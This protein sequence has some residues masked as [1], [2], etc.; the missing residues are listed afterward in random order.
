VIHP[1]SIE[2][3]LE[4]RCAGSNSR[5]LTRLIRPKEELLT[6]RHAWLRWR[7]HRHLFP[8]FYVSCLISHAFW[9]YSWEEGLWAVLE[10]EL[11]IPLHRRNEVG[12]QFRH[13]VEK[14]GGYVPPSGHPNVGPILFHCGI[15]MQA[16][17]AFAQLIERLLDCADAR[18]LIENPAFL[19]SL[20]DDQ[21]AQI[22]QKGLR[23]FLE[24]G[25]DSAVAWIQS[26]LGYRLSGRPLVDHPDAPQELMRVLEEQLCQ[27]AP[28]EKGS[29]VRHELSWDST[30]SALKLQ[31]GGNDH[32]NYVIGDHALAEGTEEHTLR[33]SDLGKQLRVIAPDKE[34]PLSVLPQHESVLLFEAFTGKRVRRREIE[35]GSYVLVAGTPSPSTADSA[36][37]TQEPSS[38]ILDVSSLR[39]MYLEVDGHG[40][41]RHGSTCWKVV[42]NRSGFRLGSSPIARDI[43]GTA[44]YCRP[45]G[46]QHEVETTLLLRRIDPDTEELL[47]EFEIDVDPSQATRRCLSEAQA[48]LY[49]IIDYQADEAQIE[50]F[51]LLPG[52]LVSPEVSLGDATRSC[53]LRLRLPPQAELLEFQGE[54]RPC[55][56]TGDHILSCSF[57]GLFTIRLGLKL[58]GIECRSELSLR[59]SSRF[60]R[61]RARFR[62]VEGPCHFAPLPLRLD[63]DQIRIL[64]GLE[65]MLAPK[66]DYFVTVPGL[67]EAR[68]VTCDDLGRNRAAL[69]LEYV[70]EAARKNAPFDATLLLR[71][72][73]GQ[74]EI[75]ILEPKELP[76]LELDWYGAGGQVIG[77]RVVAV[78]VDLRPEL[79]LRCRFLPLL[80]LDP[81]TKMQSCN[82]AATVALEQGFELPEEQRQGLWLALVSLPG[83]NAEALGAALV[84]CDAELLQT[85]ED[86]IESLVA[87]LLLH[88]DDKGAPSK[89]ELRA[90]AESWTREDALQLCAFLARS[91]TALDEMHGVAAKSSA[92]QRLRY[93]QDLLTGSLTSGGRHI[94]LALPAAALIEA[95]SDLAKLHR[96][97][98]EAFTQGSD[99]TEF[100]RFV[101]A[102]RRVLE[103]VDAGRPEQDPGLRSMGAKHPRTLSFLPPRQHFPMFRPLLED[104]ARG[105]R[106]PVQRRLRE[107]E[108]HVPFA[109]DQPLDEGFLYYSCA[110]LWHSVERQR[111][112]PDFARFV[113]TLTE[114]WHV[115]QGARQIEGLHPL[116]EQV[117]GWCAELRLPEHLNAAPFFDYLA[118]LLECTAALALWNRL[119]AWRC[120]DYRSFFGG[121]HTETPL[122][123]LWEPMIEQSIWAMRT[124]PEFYGAL[125]VRADLCL[126]RGG[127]QPPQLPKDA[128]APSALPSP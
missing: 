90:L 46:I 83:R 100:P 77:A 75:P 119:L 127:E 122:R 115:L 84:C 67:D 62:N 52:L 31:F 4:L 106:G 59:V 36:K 70:V 65:L 40:E 78:E 96:P 27:L 7:Q 9:R 35:A 85:R 88:R 32:V 43:G 117:E 18:D 10:H 51:W 128:E 58:P 19:R 109:V 34:R 94:R 101:Q 87:R 74:F 72:A 76:A 41:L 81:K 82:A 71:D 50:Q 102:Y 121:I 45:P 60:A 97:A 26:L 125:L 99:I 54:E 49:E 5:T 3:S 124:M 57:Q 98:L 33:E 64:E 91:R 110:P 112:R 44:I 89:L 118:Q 61:A 104:V 53:E 93:A 15:P 120:Q 22:P 55:P 69:P 2:Q 73:T 111:L 17:H 14:L 30:A 23:K 24:E 20:L 66:Q 92:G 25:V 6:L 1:Q 13:A 116:L 47:E 8:R 123:R 56:K 79:Q 63:L 16:A 29:R 113:A 86:D 126:A 42:A 12:R 11:E 68:S 38:P 108:K 103:W 105:Q 107:F 48:G 39:A 21:K 28:K 95:G 37:L 80:G 114:A